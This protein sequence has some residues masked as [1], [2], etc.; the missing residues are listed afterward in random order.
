MGYCTKQKGKKAPWKEPLY[1]VLN[2]D[3]KFRLKFDC[4]NCQMKIYAEK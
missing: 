4:I 1:L 3:R 2:D